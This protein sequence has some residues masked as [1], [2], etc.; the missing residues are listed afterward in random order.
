MFKLTVIGAVLVAATTAAVFQDKMALKNLV[1]NNTIS[2][3]DEIVNEVLDRYDANN[4]GSLSRTELEALVDDELA[5][6][7]DDD[8]DDDDNLDAAQSMV[9]QTQLNK[10]LTWIPRSR[11]IYQIYNSYTGGFSKTTLCN[12]I[13]GRSN[14]I[15]IG[16]TTSGAVVGGFTGNALIPT[17]ATSSWLSASNMFV[18][19]LNTYTKWT[20]SYSTSNIWINTQTSSLDIIDFGWHNALQFE[21][22]GYSATVS[23]IK[24]ND[25]YSDP[26]SSQMWVTSSD[27]TLAQFEVFQVT[28]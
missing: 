22:T 8:D 28:Y 1:S 4:D 10:F 15:F 9:T 2:E 20:S 27:T 14:L 26:T 21:T 12:T 13:K 25:F 3:R 11:S 18:F 23:Y 19:N 17:Y 6:D 16:R 7:D 5:D 24:S